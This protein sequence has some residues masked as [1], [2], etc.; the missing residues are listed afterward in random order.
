MPLRTCWSGEKVVSV[1]AMDVG[2]PPVMSEVVKVCCA[3]GCCTMTSCCGTVEVGIGN[4]GV[5]VETLM[6]T[7][8]AVVAVVETGGVEVL[9]MSALR[10]SCAVLVLSGV[11]LRTLEVVVGVRYWMGWT[12]D[13]PDDCVCVVAD[14]CVGCIDGI[15]GCWNGMVV[16]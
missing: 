1:V 4:D 15:I 6:L 11:W 3:M 10:R 14:V 12:L 13:V 9:P 8:V 5:V 16:C 2:A 7:G